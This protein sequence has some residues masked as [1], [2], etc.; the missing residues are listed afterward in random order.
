M[1]HKSRPVLRNLWIVVDQMLYQLSACRLLVDLQRN[2][3]IRCSNQLSACLEK[4]ICY[5]VDTCI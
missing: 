4:N 1:L 3:M 5:I 2:K